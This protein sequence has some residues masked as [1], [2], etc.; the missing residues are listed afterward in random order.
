M[1][2]L[3]IF[4]LCYSIII[5]IVFLTIFFI[6][7]RFEEFK[8]FMIYTREIQ[9][10]TLHARQL[11]KEIR[12]KAKEANELLYTINVNAKEKAVD[13]IECEDTFIDFSED[14]VVSFR[15][16][17]EGEETNINSEEY[18]MLRDGVGG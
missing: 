14:T 6:H 2:M 16:R 7:N 8:K 3:N 9:E 17:N 11:S 13:E 1:D 18:I 4:L 10:N 15:R 12:E 5:T